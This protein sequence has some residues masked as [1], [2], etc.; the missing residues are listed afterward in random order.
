MAVASQQRWSPEARECLE[1]YFMNENANPKAVD[2]QDL[3]AREPLLLGE[4]VER[5][6]S[7]FNNRRTKYKW[8]RGQLAPKTGPAKIPDETQPPAGRNAME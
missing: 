7:W 8:A 6:V 1:S 5:A 2:L 4:S 3:I